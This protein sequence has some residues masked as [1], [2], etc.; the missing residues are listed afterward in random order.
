MTENADKP[1]KYYPFE[2]PGAHGPAM[3]LFTAREVFNGDPVGFAEWELRRAKQWA[4]LIMNDFPEAQR[5]SKRGTEIQTQ[6]S[7]HRAAVNNV[8]AC[9][10]RLK[11]ARQSAAHKKGK[12][13]RASMDTESMT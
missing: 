13:K 9:E 8:V 4:N 5:L 12:K 10:G 3:S 2:I 11:R 1:Y 7:R 6:E